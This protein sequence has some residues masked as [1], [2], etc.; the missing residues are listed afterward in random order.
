MFE[1]AVSESVLQ[2]RAPGARW[3]LTGWNGG[4]ADSDAVY[5]VTVPDGWDRTDLRAY[6]AER[7]TAA[8]FD[9]P[10]PALLTGVEMRHAA[11]AEIDGVRAVATAGLSNP[12]A[13]P[14]DP[15]GEPA[16]LEPQPDPGT[17]NLLVGTD[18]ALADGTLATLL[19]TVV[20]AKTATVQSVTGFTGT[21][22]DAVAVGTDPGGAPAEFAGSAT[23]VGDAARSAVRR[24]VRDSLAS[25]ETPP[26]ESVSQADSGINTNRDADAFDP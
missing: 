12:A 13:L 23:A 6:A 22:S 15:D 24:A 9:T 17:I 5:N 14:L 8:G 25:R 21:T 3:L 7:R 2:A 18:R 26:P 11:G 16:E 19:A 1:T 20:E 4:Y 10:G